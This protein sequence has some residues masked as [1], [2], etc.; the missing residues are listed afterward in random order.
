MAHV[1]LVDLSVDIPGDHY[2]A[3]ESRLLVSIVRPPEC[4]GKTLYMYYQSSL[5]FLFIAYRF[6]ALSRLTLLHLPSCF[7][8]LHSALI[9]LRSRYLLLIRVLVRLVLYLAGIASGLVPSI[10]RSLRKSYHVYRPAC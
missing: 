1:D 4:I 5:G 2:A 6:I 7:L 10:D 9:V 8:P 3:A